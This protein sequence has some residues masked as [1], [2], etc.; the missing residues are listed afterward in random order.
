M[1]SSAYGST[2]LRAIFRETTIGVIYRILLVL[3]FPG[4]VWETVTLMASNSI[5]TVRPAR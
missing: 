4:L 5:C 3:P 2:G 1:N